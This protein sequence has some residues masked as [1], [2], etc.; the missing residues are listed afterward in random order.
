MK[1]QHTRFFAVLLAFVSAIL[2]SSCEDDEKSVPLSNV[3]WTLAL[4]AETGNPVLS[5]LKATF[6][7]I[8]TNTPYDGTITTDRSGITVTATVPEG[9]YRLAAEG[10]ISYT[11]SDS[12][13][14]PTIAHIR[15]YQE[16]VTVSGTTVALPAQ[17]M[18]FYNPSS[19]FV[20]EEIYFTGST[21]PTADQYNADQ[22]IKIYNNS[23]EVLYAD[24]LAILESAFTT[25]TKWEYTPDLMNEAFS[26][27]F[28]FVIPGSGQEHPVQPG[29]SLLIA[30]D[31][32]NHKEANPNSFDL[33]VADFEFYDE[34]SNP[35][36]LDNQNP[37]VPDLEKWY[38]PTASYTTL[39]NRGF[40]SY[41]IARMEVGKETF[42]SNYAYTAHYL[43]IFNEFSRP[44]STDCYYVPNAWI[45]D[46]VNLSIESGF[47]WIVTSPSLDAGWTH[48]GSIDKDPDR[49][50]KSVRRK[51]SSTVNGRKILTDT[52]NSTLDF[53]ADA[54]PSLKE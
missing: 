29:E 7:N 8:N 32:S 47:K 25:T 26:V 42:L 22:Y 31:G 1:T 16:S 52:N 41:A 4:P 51:V 53:E 36:F 13:T 9:L 17:E 10:K 23:S 18:S 5:D 46:A 35:N 3:S 54:T 43:F 33:S 11:V 39:H 20:I 50:N 40:K 34:S 27:S 44:M 48:C 15:A 24:G 19:G 45:V 21:T 12:I 49:Y 38:S 37:Q 6:T 2:L 28:I 14:T 30:L